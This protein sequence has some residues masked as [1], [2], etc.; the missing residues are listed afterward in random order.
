MDQGMLQNR[1]VK[2]TKTKKNLKNR[3]IHMK[4][5][6]WLKLMRICEILS[7]LNCIEVLDTDRLKSEDWLWVSPTL[8]TEKLIDQ[9]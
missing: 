9:K 1:S 8:I 5:K 7:R 6:L 3:E 2:K 4:L